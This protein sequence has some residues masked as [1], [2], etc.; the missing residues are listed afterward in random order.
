MVR[1]G[2]GVVHKPLSYSLTGITNFYF[3]LELLVSLFWASALHG[4]GWLSA[5]TKLPTLVH[6][7]LST[8]WLNL[9][10]KAYNGVRIVQ[11]YFFISIIA[12]VFILIITISIPLCHFRFRPL[13][14]N[15]REQQTVNSSK[16]KS[17]TTSAGSR[18]S[19]KTWK[20]DGKYLMVHTLRQ[21]ISAIPW[22]LP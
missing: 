10:M 14:Q 2:G 12:C 18:L 8:F 21:R 5:I 1:R 6:S 16:P 15:Q 4:F 17:G 11:L 13:S 9:S 22:Q 3:T 20:E 7:C 19:R